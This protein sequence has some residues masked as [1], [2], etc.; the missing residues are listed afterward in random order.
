MKSKDIIQQKYKNVTCP[1]CNSNQVKKDGKR[2]TQ[3]RGK[4]QRNR[5]K[6]C[7]FR[8]VID[9]GFYRM[10]NN[11]NKITAGIDLYYKGV[12]LRKVQEHFQAF[13][14]HNSSHMSVYRWIVKYSTMVS[15]LTD[16]MPI[17]CGKEMMS[18][19]MEYHRR[20]YHQKGMKGIEQNWFVD[21]FDLQTR[22]MI[23]GEYIKSRTNE[24][25][26][27]IM[28][29]TKF[30]TGEQ[31]KI[32]TTDGLQGYP[33]V[34]RKTFSLQSPY[35]ASSRTKSK[36]IHNVVIADERGFNYPIE[37]LHN[38]IRERTKVMRGF[39]GCLESAHA[40]MKGL[41]I[42][43]N[44]NRKHMSL[45]KRTPAEFAIPQLELGVNRWLDLIKMSR[46]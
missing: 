13:Y 31:V 17:Q 14:P 34:L 23:V 42:N 11:E 41:E 27:K 30:K 15:N 8:F 26:I 3:N 16:N 36:I 9:D 37:R 19:E 5:C 21:T 6:E 32:V 28:K 22:F 18:D 4:I 1:K 24:N 44:F 2:K 10:R 43:Y 38:T 29:K 39:H 33:T 12:S 7:D 20:L 35:H 40:I 45:G 25:L 46:I